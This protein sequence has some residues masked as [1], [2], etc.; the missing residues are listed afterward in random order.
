M[1]GATARTPAAERLR[2]LASAA[3]PVRVE[4]ALA[5]FDSL[6]P[7]SVDDMLGDWDG[8]V[9]A[10]G[11]RG[12]RHLGR[13]RWAGKRFTGVEEVDPM[14]CLDDDGR[15]VPSDVMGAARLRMVEFRGVVSAT[16]IYDRHPILDHFRRVARDTVAGVMDT[17]GDDAP[18]VFFLRRRSG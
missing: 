13:L 14:I 3:A 18:L 6:P 8:G 2:S 5:F 11:H 12:E 4:E 15:R 7:V 10:T 16:M 17:K 9:V 1:E